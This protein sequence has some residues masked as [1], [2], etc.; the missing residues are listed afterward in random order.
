MNVVVSLQSFGRLCLNEIKLI[1]HMYSYY[2]WGN[3]VNVLMTAADFIWWMVLIEGGS[4]DADKI[5][6]LALGYVVWAFANYIIYDAN[7][8]IS[9]ASQTGVLE[10]MYISNSQIHK[11]LLV[12]CI[13]ATAFCSLEQLAILCSVFLFFPLAIPLSFPLILVFAITI[14]GIFGFSFIVGGIGLI[15]KRSQPFCYMINNILLFLNGAILP[16]EKMPYLLQVI[17]K[18][19]PTTQGIE[20]MRAIAFENHTLSHILF[21]G[22]LLILIGNSCIYGIIGWVTLTYCERYAQTKGIIGQY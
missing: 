16:L 5:A 17:S 19:L 14:A 9:E 7:N 12:R 6:P 22:S 21:N 18:T 3:I 13:A 10:Q 15:F 8:V 1:A 11:H 20:L 4:L 2:K